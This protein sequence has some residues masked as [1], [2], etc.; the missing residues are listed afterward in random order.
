M[1][2]KAGSFGK[3]PVGGVRSSEGDIPAKRNPCSSPL[4]DGEMCTSS[5]R[6][7]FGGL[8]G[9]VNGETEAILDER[10]S[11]TFALWLLG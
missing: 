4:R 7:L 9:G 11:S 10:T 1:S 3:G 8:V 6:E 2:V 5:W